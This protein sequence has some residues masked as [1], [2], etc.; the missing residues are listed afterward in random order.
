MKRLVLTAAAGLLLL[1]L[2]GELPSADPVKVIELDPGSSGC[3]FK[4]IGGVSA[5]TSSR[6]LIDYPEPQRSEIL[7][8]LFKPQ[9]GASLQHLKVEISGDVNCTDGVGPSH[10]HSRTDENYNR[11]YE[12]WLMKKAK[13]RN[14][15][16]ILDCRAWGKPAWI[17]NGKYYSQDMAD[18]VV[19]FIK[20]GQ[21]DPWAGDQS[22]P[23]TCSTR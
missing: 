2:I 9:Y 16:I 12:W 20:G 8:Y 6:L 22:P 4:G 19:K 18:Y 1:G 5:G 14:P 23:R 10:M 13:I 21:E 11:G 17:G 3:L 7:D 15:D